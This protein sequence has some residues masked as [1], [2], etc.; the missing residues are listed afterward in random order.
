VPT[1]AAIA[2]RLGTTPYLLNKAVRSA[3]GVGP[4]TLIRQLFVQKA[5]RL[6]LFTELKVAAVGF[7]LGVDDPAHFVRLFRRETG[8][9]PGMWR[10]RERPAMSAGRASEPGERT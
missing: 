7:A 10:D 5:K 8:V 6:L 4:A 3:T 9:T 1:V 2:Q